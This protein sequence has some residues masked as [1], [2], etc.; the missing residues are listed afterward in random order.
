[1]TAELKLFCR[2]LM[3]PWAE[4][5]PGAKRYKH[6]WESERLLLPEETKTA[7]QSACDK[8]SRC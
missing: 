6:H 4:C 3:R 8:V 2:T 7:Q 1:M 5:L